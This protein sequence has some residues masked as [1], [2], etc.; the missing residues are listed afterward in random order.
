VPEVWP[1]T[2]PRC[3]NLGSNEQPGDP[4]IRSQTDIGPAKVRRRSSSAVSQ[5]S[6]VM[7]MTL[8]QWD[9]LQVFGDV[10]LGGWVEPFLFPEIGGDLVRFGDELPS[11]TNATAR[12]VSVS[13]T[14]EVLP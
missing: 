13:I 4:R 6:G 10:N 7:T 9:A 8:A 12:S 11:R 1:T 5:R 14:L 2:L 3:F